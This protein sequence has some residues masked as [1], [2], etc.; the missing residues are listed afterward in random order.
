MTECKAEHAKRRLDYG[1]D[2]KKTPKATVNG[3]ILKHKRTVS[4]S[5]FIS[6]HMSK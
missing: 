4:S 3:S 1:N 2:H 6:F 5:V